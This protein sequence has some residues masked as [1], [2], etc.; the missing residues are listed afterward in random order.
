MNIIRFELPF[1]YSLP[2]KTNG[3]HYFAATRDK[4]AMHRAVAAASVGLRP[5]EPFQRARVEIERHG[6][7][8]PD[9]DNLTGGAKRLIDCLTTPRLLN[10]RTEGARQRV[11]N[12]RGLGFIIDDGPEHIVLNV[13]HVPARLCAQ[14]TVMTITEI[15]P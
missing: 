2:N 15:L 1:A 6:V 3:Q 9:P 5:P 10:V 13:R 11:K 7:R 4:N 14:K 8:A 12:K